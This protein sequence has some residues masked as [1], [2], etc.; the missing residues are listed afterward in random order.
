MAKDNQSSFFTKPQI[1]IDNETNIEFAIVDLEIGWMMSKWTEL[2]G[3]SVYIRPSFGVGTNR[4][5]DG[6]VEVGYKIVG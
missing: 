2:K 4:P 1:A 3:R 5:V 6:S